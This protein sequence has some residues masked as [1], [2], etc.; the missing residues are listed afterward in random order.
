MDESSLLV[1]KL[2]KILLN[3]RT[4]EYNNEKFALDENKNLC[5]VYGDKLISFDHNMAFLFKMAESIGNDNLW[6]ECCS[7]E[8]QKMKLQKHIR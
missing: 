6:L 4:V 3:G 1:N 8:L 7:I 2:I 5:V